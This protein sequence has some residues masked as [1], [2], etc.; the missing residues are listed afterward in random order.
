MKYS[1]LILTAI[2]T[3][4]VKIRA[5]TTTINS[6]FLNE[7]RIIQIE[8]PKDYQETKLNYPVIYV[9]DGNLLFDVLKAYYQYNSE[10]YPEAILVG[11]NQNNRGNELIYNSKAD[12]YNTN[13]KFTSFFLKEVIPYI[14]KNYRANDFNLVIGHSHGGTFVLNTLI[15]SPK[16]NNCISI[17]PTVWVNN[18]ELIKKLREPIST[19][20]KKQNLY[21][22][23]GDKEHEAFQNG[24]M[25][26]KST[27]DSIP[28]NQFILSTKIL[29][30][31]DHNSSIL[32]GMRKGL[33]HFFKDYIFPEEKWDE[34][35]ESKNDQ[36]FLEY[37]QNLSDKLH[38]QVIPSEDD[39][40]S[41]AYFY[42]ENKNYK[43][44]TA[45]FKKNIANHPSSSN[46]Y[47]SLGEA[48]ENM[49]KISEAKKLY[50]KALIIEKNG[51]N[52]PFQIKQYNNH[53]KNIKN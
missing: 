2:I 11:I 47:D 6:N 41:L 23:C 18:Y 51:E 26:I 31:E 32:T 19:F 8:L 46:T 35:E 27:I 43:K 1:I 9:F 12:L 39:L 48:F 36:I 20:S 14:N 22:A 49:G 34:L 17:S 40:N 42:L 21:L 33:D 38:F 3:I 52:N 5:Q 37:F 16:I 30:D 10:I 50:Q 15:N 13:E 28:K 53:L 7:N 24:I 4:H 29:P 25:K 44:A 45:T